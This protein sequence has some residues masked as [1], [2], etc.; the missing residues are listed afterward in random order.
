MQLKPLLLALATLTLGSCATTYD[1]A[2]PEDGVPVDLVPRYGD[3]DRAADP[4]LREGDDTFIS[5]ISA[6]FGSREAAS[7]HMSDYGM[8]LYIQD[9]LEKAM[10]RLN[11]A[12]LLDPANPE[13]YWGFS[14]IYLD[15]GRQD[16][17]E[18]W[19][20]EALD[21]GLVDPEGLVSAAFVFARGVTGAPPAADD[22][23]RTRVEELC[24]RAVATMETKDADYVESRA[25]MAL[26]M[27]ASADRAQ[28]LLEARE[29]AGRTVTEEDWG[30][31]EALRAALESSAG[32]R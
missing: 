3:M 14:V 29:A 20:N 13:T 25:V 1:L 17:A 2:R 30:R 23:V 16:L 8:R 24:A 21:Q 22:P 9:D 19:M 7:R 4:R 28:A 15:L 11:Q 5:G 31:L 18:R 32:A 27:V 10:R 26:G 6:E 12:W